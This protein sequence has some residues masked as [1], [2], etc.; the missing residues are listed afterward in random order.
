MKRYIYV[1]FYFFSPLILA[2]L[3]YVSNPMKYT[4]ITFM[5]SMLSGAF[6]YTWLNWQF[7]I[8]ARPKF[9]EK[10][11]GM[12][13]LYR[14]HGIMAVFSLALVGVHRIIN[15]NIFSVS[16][17]I[18]IGQASFIVFII[19]SILSIILMTS[20]AS[21]SKP[22]RRIKTLIERIPLFKYRQLK[23]IHNVSIA[24]LILLQIHVLMTTAVK[25]N[26]IVF[27]GYMS[28][29]LLSFGFYF[30][31]KVIKRWI[32]VDNKYKIIEVAQES[33]DMWRIDFLT[34]NEIT[35][36]PGQFAFFRFVADKSKEEHPFTI[37][38]SPTENGYMSVTIKELGDFTSK[39]GNIRPGDELIIEGPYGRFS[40]LNNTYEENVVF[41]VGG[42]G[43][44]PALSMVKHMADSYEKRKV[45]L[46]WGVR[47]TRDIIGREKLIELQRTFP[48]LNIIPVVSDEPEYI[49]E[50]GYINKEILKRLLVQNGISPSNAGYYVCGPVGLMKSVKTALKAL[51]VPQELIH[52]ERFSL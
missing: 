19:I 24:A 29:F 51:G 14:V 16:R 48:N 38:S 33:G 15:L 8:S 34:N 5:I 17:M 46:I 45:L 6:A 26:V 10:I 39:I 9:I 13:H 25:A 3:L 30:Y 4:N 18:N 43:V 7:I 36:Q 31:H 23:I 22:I 50:K 47:K 40:Y 28:Y 12:D 27:S 32:L 21:R 49:G 44:T 1:M 41:I 42:V 35:Y 20:L 52:D 2:T 37:S 11:F